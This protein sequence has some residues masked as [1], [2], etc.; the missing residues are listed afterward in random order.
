MNT[1]LPSLSQNSQGATDLKAVVNSGRSSRTV[2]QP[3]DQTTEQLD[4]YSSRKTV[5]SLKSRTMIS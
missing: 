2:E 4:R 1:S 3:H 5:D